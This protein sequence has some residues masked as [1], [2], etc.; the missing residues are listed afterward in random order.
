MLHLFDIDVLCDVFSCETKRDFTIFLSSVL[1]PFLYGVPE[2]Q[3]RH[4]YVIASSV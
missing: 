1:G 3:L 4:S 2:V